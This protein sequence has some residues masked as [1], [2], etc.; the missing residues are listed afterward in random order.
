MW[1]PSWLGLDVSAFGER[2]ER[3][4]RRRLTQGLIRPAVHELKQLDRELDVPQAAGAELD[5]PV[6]FAGG[7]VRYDPAAHR[8]HVGHEIVASGRLPDEAG[9]GGD[10]VLA[11]FGVTGDRPGLEQCLELPGLR[12]ALVV[13]QVAGDRSHQRAGA[14]FWAKV[15]VDGEHRA[16]GSAL[17]A[18]PDHGAGQLG[19]RLDRDGLV[20]TSLR[21]LGHEDDIDVAGVIELAGA[22]FA[23]RDHRDGVDWAAARAVTRRHGPRDPDRAAGR[24]ERHLL[25]RVQDKR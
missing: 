16:L 1:A 13:G 9:N 7:Q 12:P 15:G 2:L 14:P 22:A 18:D 21:P 24:D 4:Q 25:Y 17:G 10:V 6:G 19:G 8:L 20:T 3:R 23:H 11:E 5:L